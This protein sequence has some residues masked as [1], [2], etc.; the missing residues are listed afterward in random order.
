MH[1][2]VVEIGDKRKILESTDPRFIKDGLLKAREKS[3]EALTEIRSRLSAGMTEIEAQI[4]ANQRLKELGST[5]NWHKP[6]V[7]FGPGTALSYHSP[8][9]SDYR[10]KTG[11]PVYLDIGPVVGRRGA[12]NRI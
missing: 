5:K 8:L 4:T 6:V 2:L 12:Q 7:R 9:Q 3:W 10:L 11:D 1:A